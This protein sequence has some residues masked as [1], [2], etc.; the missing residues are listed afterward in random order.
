MG[1][2]SVFFDVGETIVDESREYGAW[3]DW[4]GVPRHTFWAVFGAVIAQGLDHREAFRLLRPGFD[5]GRRAGTGSRP[6]RP[7]CPGW[8][9]NTTRQQAS[10]CWLA[11]R[12]GR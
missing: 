5:P 10:A 6:P 12:P 8:S 1:I 4:L 11:S 7:S 2:R 3:A 9:A